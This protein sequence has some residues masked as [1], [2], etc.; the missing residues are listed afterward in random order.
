VNRY[1]I[2]LALKAYTPSLG[3]WR[4][5]HEL[6]P[7]QIAEALQYHKQAVIEAQHLVEAIQELLEMERRSY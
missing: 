6:S 5:L 1:K 3:E 7:E 4:T 2:L